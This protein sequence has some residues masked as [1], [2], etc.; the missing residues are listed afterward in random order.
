MVQINSYTE[1]ISEL[2]GKEKAWLL[3]YKKG[4]ERSDCAYLHINGAIFTLKNINIYA[5][6]INTVKDIH[7]H[8]KIDSVPA[9]LEFEN[10]SVR[11]IVKGCHDNLN[12][13]V[14][15]EGKVNNVLVRGTGNT[16]ETGYSIF[17]SKLFLV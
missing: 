11:N 9:L 12:Y 8:F 2:E 7:P 3:L 13:K 16:G 5:A 6:D 17:N 15:F 10:G 1:L 14:L 4:S